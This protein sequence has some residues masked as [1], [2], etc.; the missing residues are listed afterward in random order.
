MAK[1]KLKYGLRDNKLVHINS[2]EKG[3][4]CDCVCP[5][6]EQPL[7]AKKGKVKEH[8]FA[9]LFKGYCQCAYETMLH[10][11]AKEIIERNKVITLPEVVVNFDSNR[12]PLCLFNSQTIPIES[13]VLEKKE[14]DIIPDL[15]V[16]YRG[17]KLLLEIYVTHKLDEEKIEYLSNKEISCIEIDLSKAP[18]DLDYD[19][20]KNLVLN[21][22]SNKSWIYNKKSNA[23]KVNLLNRAKE[24]SII[25]SANKGAY[26]SE[27]K[28]LVDSCPILMEKGY[29]D[30]RADAYWDCLYCDNCISFG[31][32]SILCHP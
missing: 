11:L 28:H 20:I 26:G 27:R 1:R 16:N 25:F 19:S 12:R 17:T 18:R 7:V 3:G 21:E 31:D 4:I 10:I 2:I 30:T 14:G 32:N 15:I 8:H 13:V 5:H 24:K 23:K 22:T 29:L 6:C 9:H